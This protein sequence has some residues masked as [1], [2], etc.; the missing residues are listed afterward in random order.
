MQNKIPFIKSGKILVYRLYD[1]ANEIDLLKVENRIK[2]DAKRLKITRRPFSKAFEFA[3]PPISFELK[4][5]DKEINNKKYRANVYCKVY[6]F[7]VLG[8]IFDFALS[9]LDVLSYEDLAM[10]IDIDENIDIEFRGY[11][12]QV[13]KVLEGCFTGFNISRFEEDYTIFFIEKF[14]PELDFDDFLN[15]YDITRLMFSEKG[16]FSKKISE[17]LISSRS[18]YYK[19]DGVILNWDNALVVEPSGSMEIPDLLE[20]AKAQLLELRYYD[21]VVDGELA[22]IQ[23]SITEKGSLSIWKIRKYER[24]AA[25]IMQTITELT[26][27]T[28]KIDTSLKVTED[29]YYAKVYMEAINLFKVKEWERNIK[30]KLDIA[31]NA[32][33]MLYREISNKRLELLELAIVILIMIDIVIWIIE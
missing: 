25:K 2:K 5:F 33:D 20:F 8:I 1:V 32:C 19:N 26:E 9:D 29:V 27:I 3:N 14:S 24:L 15:S 7:G 30:K 10:S 17:E 12:D 31:S 11:L 28:E 4:G 18:S 13:V 16:N 6:D 21:H 22:H 23:D